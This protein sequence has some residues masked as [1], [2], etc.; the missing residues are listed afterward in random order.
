MH[1]TQKIG[2]GLAEQSGKAD[3]EPVDEVRMVGGDQVDERLE[4]NAEH[5][6]MG[7]MEHARKQ[8]SDLLQLRPTETT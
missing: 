4:E 3:V 8:V 1:R 6:A 7:V 5:L 2:A